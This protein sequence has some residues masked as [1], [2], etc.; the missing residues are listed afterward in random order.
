MKN[1]LF[2]GLKIMVR[3]QLTQGLREELNKV[4]E[5]KTHTNSRQFISKINQLVKNDPL[6]IN[7]VPLPQLVGY[8]SHILYIQCNDIYCGKAKLL[9]NLN[10]EKSNMFMSLVRYGQISYPNK[11]GN[12]ALVNNENHLSINK[13]NVSTT[14]NLSNSEQEHL[15][16]LIEID[17]WLISRPSLYS[18][19]QSFK[20]YTQI[21][22]FIWNYNLHQT[23]SWEKVLATSI[24][25]I[26]FQELLLLITHGCP[27]IAY[28]LKLDYI[29]A[30]KIFDN[31][32]TEYNL[33]TST[34]NDPYLT[35]YYDGRLDTVKTSISN[36]EE[37]ED[38]LNNWEYSSN[39]ELPIYINTFTI[40]DIIV[41]LI[42][43]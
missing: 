2:R 13:I 32:E 36:Y 35:D 24:G 16:A 10:F 25:D 40:A 39:Q 9:S 37:I 23:P 42:T 30:T 7:L 19:Q 17:D 27:K 29:K 5:S 33:N 8:F 3:L 31:L 38:E 11:F 21:L 12:R 26:T 34:I 1:I 41:S 14:L 15:E 28:T 43:D 20:Q 4:L 6:K 22:E 18:H